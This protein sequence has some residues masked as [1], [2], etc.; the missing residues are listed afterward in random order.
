MRRLST[1]AATKVIVP[2]LRL[3]PLTFSLMASLPGSAQV[4]HDHIEGSGADSPRGEHGGRLL[5]EA[6]FTLELAIFEDGLA[7]EFRAWAST[8]DTH[9]P[10]GTWSLT[11]ELT[12]LGGDVELFEFVPANDYLKSQGSVE[13][14][15]SFEVRVMARYE[16]R[17]YNWHYDSFEGRV[18]LSD[19]LAERIGI[20]VATAG[21]GIIHQ[22]ETLFG[23]ISPDPRQVSHITARY[24]GLIQAVR[25]DLGDHVEQGDLI[26]TIE[27]NDSLQ[28]YQ[29]HAPITGIVVDSHANPGEFAG[30]DH[31][32]TIADYSSVWA[33]LNVFPRS[34]QRIRPGQAVTLRMGDLNTSST[35][36]YLNPGEGLSPSI[37]ARVP[38]SNADL[39]WTPG[40]LVEADVTVGKFEIPLLI[41]NLA[42]Q[43]YRDWQVV[44]VKVGETYEIRPVK[45][46]RSDGRNSEVLSG[47]KPGD[48]YVIDNSYLLKADLEK[49]GATHSH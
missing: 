7:P 17:E 28:T 12:R 46:G 10:P 4:V 25:P 42:L 49:S 36:R 33:D 27:A 20:S 34:A 23:K 21:A 44:F 11:V 22:T 45:L 15:H 18:Q 1:L 19:A 38:I 39:V 31:L 40:L 26:A 5:Q 47:L 16:G 13:E 37:I 14:P 32:L 6:E 9:P 48:R 43:E 3:L 30:S 8:G 29:I 2:I 41:N 24:P 35:I